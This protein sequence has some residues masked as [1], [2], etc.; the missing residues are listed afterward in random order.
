MRVLY[1]FLFIAFGLN[2]SAQTQN[3]DS[4]FQILKDENLILKQQDNSIQ[5]DI[6]G[7][8]EGYEN[9]LKEYNDIKDDRDFFSYV[10]IVVAAVFGVA[11][12]Q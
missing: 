3:L 9:L 10:L 4:L 6:K 11:L 5:E 2:L 8:A 1:F 7:L 12:L